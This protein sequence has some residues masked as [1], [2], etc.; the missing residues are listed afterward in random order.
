MRALLEYLDEL[1]REAGQPSYAEIGRAVSLA[2]STLSAFFTGAR[3]ISKG[4]LAFLVEHLGGDTARAERLRRKAAT[5]WNVRPREAARAR[6]PD[7]ERRAIA[8]HV[9]ISFSREDRAYVAAL[10]QFLQAADLD[11]WFDRDIAISE[12]WPSVIVEQIDT[13]TAV[14]V[15]MTP[16]AERSVWVDR[17]INRAEQRG[18]EI[19]PLLLRG[20]P[21]MRLNDRHYTS[22]V[23]GQL[24]RTEFVNRLRALAHVEGHDSVL[25]GPSRPS[26]SESA[27]LVREDWGDAPYPGRFYGRVEEGQCEASGDWGCRPG[28]PVAPPRGTVVRSSGACKHSSPSATWIEPKAG[29]RNEVSPGWKRAL[30]D[31]TLYFEDRIT[32]RRLSRGLT[33]ESQTGRGGETDAG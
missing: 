18:K 11:V 22:I 16:E 15:V 30:T 10:A 28:R 31:P 23:S 13:C 17:E 4:Y 9:F 3:L 7:T 20:E 27:A 5:E 2:P 6:Q 33:Q 14:V 32:I 12:G 24:P 21:I 1:H 8:R 25:T 19:M 29:D 26:T